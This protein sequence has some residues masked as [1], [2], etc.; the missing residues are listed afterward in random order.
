[1]KQR[2]ILKSEDVTRHDHMTGGQPYDK[3]LVFGL[4]APR[5]VSLDFGPH[6]SSIPNSKLEILNTSHQFKAFK[7]EL[8]PDSCRACGILNKDRLF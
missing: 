7:T 1:M 8:H 6:T 5:E 3:Q 4:F 2:S